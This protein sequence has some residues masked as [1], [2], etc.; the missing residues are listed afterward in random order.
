MEPERKL[1]RSSRRR[2]RRVDWISVGLWIALVI[3]SFMWLMPFV[4]ILLSSL[5][6]QSEIVTNLPWTLPGVWQF[7]NYARAAETGDIWTLGLN[8]ALIALVKVPLG[9][10]IAALCAFALA[11]L[12]VRWH[13]IILGI[14]A[15]GALVPVQV[16]LGPLFSMMLQFDLLNTKVGV[17]LP[18]LAFGISFQVFI[19]YGFFRSVPRELD[20]A[21]ILDGASSWRLFWQIVVPLAKPALAALFILDFVGT[22]N[23]YPMALALLQTHDQFTVP[24]GITSFQHEHGADYG[25]MNAYIVLSVLP[26]LLVYLMFQRYFVNGAFSGAVKG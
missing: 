13:R 6:T 25:A 9:I 18:Y 26:V 23:E 7:Q 24:L 21:A 11:R 19:L 20:E 22:W 4:F 14:I 17:L 5:K 16:A 8:S 2:G 3:V 10:F 12:K 15:M 1:S